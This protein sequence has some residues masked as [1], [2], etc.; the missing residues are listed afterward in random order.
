MIATKPT[1]NSKTLLVLSGPTAVGKTALSI[2]LAQQWNTH[3]VSADSRQF[4]KELQIGVA[5]PTPEELA[6]A[7]HHFVGNLSITDY[8]NVY[9]YEQEVLA[10][11]EELF[12]QYPIII[13]VGGSGLY[14]DAVCK[15][16][17]LLPDPDEALRS[18]LQQQPIE[19]LRQQLQQIDPDYYEQVDKNNRVRLIRAIEVCTQTGVP[20]SKLRNQ[21]K[22]QRPF[23]IKKYCITQ[24][25]ETLYNRINARVDAMMQ[26]GL[27]DEVRSLYA[28][29]HLNALNTVGY[30]ELFAYLEG[31]L[32]LA[33]AIEKIKTNTRRYA[34]RQLTWFR[35]DGEYQY[36]NADQAFDTIMHENHN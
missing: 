13:M 5:A 6:A 29:R 36:I 28:Q 25:R 12:A 7:P 3:I 21:A 35:R 15:G 32:T 31:N 16:I 33:Q 23:A 34:K 8:Y 19:N 27:L 26:Q 18:R 22:Q 20:F 17:D 2:R 24:D 10:T 1:S 14:I 30:K 9:K 11:L 4:Y